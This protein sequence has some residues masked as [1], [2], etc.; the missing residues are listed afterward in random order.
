M[1]Y[2]PLSGSVAEDGTL[3]S[4][5]DDPQAQTQ[6]DADA[7]FAR[8]LQNAESGNSRLGR[9]N[10]A[11]NILNN[12][13]GR[14][15]QP[16]TAN[17]GGDETPTDAR[18][19]EA[20]QGF[21]DPANARFTLT[22]ITLVNVPQIIAAGVVLHANWSDA[23]CDKPLREWAFFSAFRMACLV[24]VS[25]AIYVGRYFGRYP[26]LNLMRPLHQQ[27]GPLLH[28]SKYCLDMLGLLWFVVG[29]L[30]VF[31][32]R[33]C[34]AA[35]APIYRLCL[36][37]V[38]ISHAMIFL[39][40]LIV[41]MV[42]PFLCL[43]FPCIIRMLARWRDPMRGK[44]AT[45]AA[46]DKLETVSFT[47]ENN[48]KQADDGEDTD[49]GKCCAI[50]LSDFEDGDKLRVMPCSHRFHKSCVDEWLRVNASCPSC[51]CDISG[52]QPST[53]SP[54]PAVAMPGGDA[55]SVADSV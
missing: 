48:E 49:N 41:V 29:N 6:I 19:A 9:N 27:I 12:Q 24:F 53:E 52:N 43:C 21:R 50:C 22:V 47:E 39:P 18:V 10:G 28:K 51:R 54:Q 35:S 45:A 1:S 25:A 11:L 42:L 5:N 55:A 33:T 20:T 4:G 13:I 38:L 17:A 36:S 14:P 3:L 31:S 8:E 7:A 16:A 30:W 37:M 26:A 15:R 44:G 40:C 32:S 2:A 34:L 46:I 23:V